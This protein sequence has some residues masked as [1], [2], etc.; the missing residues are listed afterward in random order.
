MGVIYK[1]TCS[2]NKKVYI[3][4]T[5]YTSQHRWN[6]HVYEAA[7]PEVKQSR[8]LNRCIVKYGRGSFILEDLIICDSK[9]ELDEWEIFYIEWFSSMNTELGLNL[10]SGGKKNHEISEETRQRLSDAIKGKPKYITFPRKN[11]EYNF[12]PKYLK[13]YKDS[14]GYE[15]FRIGDH[16]NIGKD[17]GKKTI[18]FTN[19]NISLSKKYFLAVSKILELNNLIDKLLERINPETIVP[20]ENKSKSIVYSTITNRPKGMQILANGWQVKIKGLQPKSF[21]SS[22]FTMDEKYQLAMNYYIE[23]INGTMTEIKRPKG[24]RKMTNGWRVVVKGFPNRTFTDSK[25]SMDEKY[26]LALEHHKI[27]IC[28]SAQF[29]D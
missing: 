29:N 12:L 26:K 24:I 28:E 10:N 6:Q 4:Q 23:L 3:G 2:T 17:D 20:L 9:E 8:L 7:H 22:D 19:P 25:L 18:S 11:I 21:Q 14:K 16:P 1:L 15:G 27:L 13:Y 5:K